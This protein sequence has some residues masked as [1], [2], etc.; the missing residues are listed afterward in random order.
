LTF[1]SFTSDDVVPRRSDQSRGS[2]REGR[3]RR[4]DTSFVSGEGTWRKPGVTVKF[5]V[6]RGLKRAH[7]TWEL[8]QY[9]ERDTG[10]ATSDPLPWFRKFTETFWRL[11]RS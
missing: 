2:R 7:T 6:K 5:K 4:A 8:H 1:G 3:G 9:R 11:G 10:G